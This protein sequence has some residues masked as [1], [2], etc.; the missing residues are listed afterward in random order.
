[1]TVEEVVDFFAPHQ[2]TVDAVTEWLAE[3]GISADRFAISANKQVP[4]SSQFPM[5]LSRFSAHAV[6]ANCLGLSGFNLTLQPPKSKS[7]SSLNSTSGSTPLG[8]MMFRVKST[9]SQPISRSISTM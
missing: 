3:S 1:M 8:L 2:S 6:N 9:M 5:E 4:P 7:Y